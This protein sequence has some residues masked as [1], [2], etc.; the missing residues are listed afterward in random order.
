MHTM[1]TEAETASHPLGTWFL[2]D[3][4]PL[5]GNWTQGILKNNEYLSSH[6]NI[7]DLTMTVWMSAY[8]PRACFPHRSHGTGVTMF[9][10]CHVGYETLNHLSIL[11]EH[12]SVLCI[13]A[14]ISNLVLHK[15]PQ[16]SMHASDFT[17]I[18]LP[19]VILLSPFGSL[20]HVHFPYQLMTRKI[21]EEIYTHKYSRN[22]FQMEKM[23]RKQEFK[24]LQEPESIRHCWM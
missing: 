5:C 6:Q 4:E 12:S 21:S 22:S 13:L 15:E 3:C 19:S 24:V 18:Y 2:D 17:L 14:F 20:N 10:R 7:S 1:S 9:V 8:L 11:D 23:F 16:I